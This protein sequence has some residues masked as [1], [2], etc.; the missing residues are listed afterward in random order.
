M[1]RAERK[2]ALIEHMCRLG[3]I[4]LPDYGYADGGAWVRMLVLGKAVRMRVATAR[5]LAKCDEPR[6]L[7]AVDPRRAVQ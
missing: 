3:Y 6:M 1:T 7:P 4:P 5:S 2:A